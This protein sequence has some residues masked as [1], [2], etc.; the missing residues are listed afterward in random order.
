MA[1]NGIMASY[2]HRENGMT[3]EDMVACGRVAN[4]S[5]EVIIFRS[6]GPW[7]Q[8]W[9]RR[10]YPTKN[11]HVKGKS[12]DW[13][14]QAGFV[15]YLGKYSKVGRDAENERTGTKY[16]EDGKHHS[17]AQKT[18]LCLTREELDIQFRELAAGRTALAE[19]HLD[20]KTGDY[21]LY[22][23]RSS[24]GVRFAFRAVWAKD[25]YKIFVFDKVL[26]LRAQVFDIPKP[27]EVMTSSEVGAKNKPMT[28]DYDLMTVC[29]TWKD[30]GERSAATIS[31]PGLDFGRGGQAEPGQSFVA[32]T[33][34]DAAVDPRLST[35]LP[36]QMTAAGKPKTFGARGFTAPQYG[37]V[38]NATRE[39]SSEHPDMGNLTPRI[40]RCIND[41]NLAMGQTGAFR[42]VHHNAESHR[43]LIFG[44]ITADDMGRG[45][46][47][48][49][50]VFQ[51]EG[52]RI[53]GYE[54]VHTL[55][56]L[57][58]FKAYATALHDAGYFV[59]RN[60]T[61][62][63][64]IRDQRFADLQRVVGKKAEDLRGK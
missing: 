29:P 56:T 17:S 53:A 11:F 21:I 26:P 44:G 30:Y 42:R 49:L 1:V 54:S 8:R 52:L 60:W 58:E 47:F 7:S 19:M 6:T 15:P 16:N 61:W 43:N 9:I 25:H 5:K 59:P 22:A 18:Q 45:E 4:R 46:A 24:D 2:Q 36:N 63:M 23:S 62:H 13:G 39:M 34:L 55:E 3:M 12:S 50:T 33:N 14:P 64:S 41:L 40:L 38:V 57:A 32:G 10:N 28:G 27:L 51:P 48:P 31:K 37:G 35:G 20:A